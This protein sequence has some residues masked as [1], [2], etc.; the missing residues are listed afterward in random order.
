MGRHKGFQLALLPVF[1][2]I[3]GCGT[4]GG[5]TDTPGGNDNTVD[6]GLRHLLT[7][8]ADDHVLGDPAAPNTIIQYADFE[9]EDCG[10][11]FV[12]NRP[13]VIAEL[14]DT[15]RA[16]LV[17]RHFPVSADQ[18]NSRL[19]AI[20]AECAADFFE[21]HD[22]LLG[23]Q[24][25]LARADLVGYAEQVGL[26]R[27]TFENCLESGA[28]VPPIERDLDTGR[29]LGVEAAPTFFVNEHVLTGNPSLGQIEALLD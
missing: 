4:T 16:T 14:V 3:V 28:K 18:P 29:Q 17:F 6:P 22:L 26:N 7:V 9:C 2:L 1:V 5:T 21:Y 8:R 23:N 24:D 27:T 19:A 20:A 15:G 11:F 12:E 10:E 25:A 13:A